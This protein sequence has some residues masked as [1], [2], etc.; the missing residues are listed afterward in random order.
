MSIL[1]LESCDFSQSS[2]TLKKNVSNDF[3]ISEESYTPLAT[4]TPSS[5]PKPTLTPT[6]TPTLNPE[7]NNAENLKK[8]TV[9]GKIIVSSLG[10][11]ISYG[12]GTSHT[13]FQ[14]QT[15]S[16]LEKCKNNMGLYNY[17]TGYTGAFARLLQKYYPTSLQVLAI[18]GGRLKTLIKDQ[19]PYLDQNATLVTVY[20]GT[21]DLPDIT[22]SINPIEKTEEWEKD[23]ELMLNLIHAKAPNAKIILLNIPNRYYLPLNGGAFLEADFLKRTMNL[24]SAQSKKM[25]QIINRYSKNQFIFSVFD[26]VCNSNSYNTDFLPDALHPND[27][28]SIALAE[29]ILNS[30][31]S[32]QPKEPASQC[33]PYF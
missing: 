19:I 20:I 12:I 28:G 32:T 15:T 31:L 21:N 14:V 3:F 29:D 10:D 2:V 9:D 5:S 18:P 30:I 24:F 22:D 6:P 25:N 4:P 8:F 27:E 33:L 1:F 23:Y 26:N 17:F 16:I 7:I 11:S 13:C